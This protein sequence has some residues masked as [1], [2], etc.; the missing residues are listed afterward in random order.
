MFVNDW[1]TGAAQQ[2]SQEVT[3]YPHVIM[4]VCIEMCVSLSSRDICVGQGFI[5]VI[6]RHEYVYNIFK[7]DI[8]LQWWTVGI[9]SIVSGLVHISQLEILNFI[10]LLGKTITLY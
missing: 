4:E 3:F 8:L 6:Q 5:K 7:W 2:K 1:I 10:S 9:V